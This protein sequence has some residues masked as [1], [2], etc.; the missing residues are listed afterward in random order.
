MWIKPDPEY[1]KVISAELLSTQCNLI[2]NLV[3]SAWRTGLF[4]FLKQNPKFRFLILDNLSAL[5]PGCD[6]SSGLEWDEISQWLLALRRIGITTLIVHHA[7]KNN[8]QRGTSKRE[9]ALDLILKLT[10]SEKRKVSAFRVDFEKAR[11]LPESLKGPFAIEMQD[12][13]EKRQMIYKPVSVDLVAKIAFLISKGCSQ[14]A[15][16]NKLKI[17]Q[18]TVSRKVATAKKDGL[19]TAK[20]TLTEWGESCCATMTED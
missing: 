5:M 6:E 14:T 2:P 17:N 19:L 12:R 4:E 16:A 18:G 15:I 3:D 11:S 10:K 13:D 7:G 20:E 8:Q 9:D 1:F